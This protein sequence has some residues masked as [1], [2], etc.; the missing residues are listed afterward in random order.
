M[1]KHDWQGC[2]ISLLLLGIIALKG[3]GSI[4][5]MDLVCLERMYLAV[6]SRHRPI[7]RNLSHRIVTC[8]ILLQLPQI[9]HLL[10]QASSKGGTC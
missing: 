6:P 7:L 4:T 8:T 9:N 3:W 5:D 2:F 1:G 10:P